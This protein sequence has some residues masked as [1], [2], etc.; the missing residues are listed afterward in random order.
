MPASSLPIPL[1]VLLAT[2]PILVVLY[3][4]IGRHWGGSKA[5]P[6]GW[7]TAIVVSLLFFGTGPQLIWIASLKAVL[8]SLFVLYIIWMALLLYHTVN[9]AGAITAIGQEMPGIAH[10]RAAQALLMAW[11][12]GSFLQG[13][14]GF[15]VPA[16]VVA[17][18]LVGIGFAATPAV[19]IALLGHTWAVTF[20]S[21]GSSF[22]SLIAA[23]GVPGTELAD[24]VSAM[25]AVAALGSGLAILWIVDKQSAVRRRGFFVLLLAVVMG[26]TQ[27]LIARSGLYSLAALGGG[28]AGLVVAIPWLSRESIK[29]GAFEEG[30]SFAQRRNRLL[31]AFLPYGILIGVVVF[32]TMIIPD[33]L[34]A[35]V[36]SPI[37]PEICTSLGVCTA[38]GPGRSINLFGHGG[39]LLFYATVLIFL[40]YRW[41]G[42]LPTAPTSEYGAKNIL[43]KTINGSIKPTIGIYTMV[44]MASIMEHAGMTQLLANVLSQSGPL[45]PFL[46]P[47]IGA[48]G[49]FMTGSNTNSN[50]VFGELQKQTALTL[51]IS[52]PII[53]AGQTAGGAIGSNFAPAK[54]IVGAST[55]AEAVEG[56]VLKTLARLGLIIIGVI[57]LVVWAAI[58]LSG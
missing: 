23:S 53:L 32:G 49:A 22:V 34:D 14:T 47:F 21:L 36:I 16:A 2:T 29:K 43:S 25:L 37:F 50:V 24:P 27:W 19:V 45:F 28:L 40:W 9:D 30:D 38:E 56:D 31:T 4:M 51:G 33:L 55:V 6:A 3:L 35:V 10:G 57:G 42:T 11:I 52:V 17:P 39:A 1:L 12:F 8:L 15:G 48:L 7:L 18:L 26:G 20:G 13:A 5:G 54:V 44:A 46:S 58:A 41:R